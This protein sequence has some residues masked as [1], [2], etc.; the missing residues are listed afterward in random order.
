MIEER[1]LKG[2]EFAEI[3]ERFYDNRESL[4]VMEQKSA[5]LSNVRAAADI[6]DAC[7]ALIGDKTEVR[8]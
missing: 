4:R 3:I 7:L 5:S 6:V 1:E 8:S 2:K